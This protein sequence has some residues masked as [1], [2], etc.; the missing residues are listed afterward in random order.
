[1]D[2]LFIEDYELV[3][4]YDSKVACVVDSKLLG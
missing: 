3:V 4:L 1:M 2:P